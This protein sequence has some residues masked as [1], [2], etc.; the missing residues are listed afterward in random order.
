MDRIL[1]FPRLSFAISLLCSLCVSATLSTSAY[2]QADCARF[3]AVTGWTATF[4]LTGQ[5]EGADPTGF[6]TTVQRSANGSLQFGPLDGSCTA[7]ATADPSVIVN[8]NDRQVITS[9]DGSITVVQTVTASGAVP[10]PR[11]QPATLSIDAVA[12][13]YNLHTNVRPLVDA[14]IVT[15]GDTTQTLAFWVPC[16]GGNL[17]DFDVP[18]RNVPLPAS[19]TVL[20]GEA[21]YTAPADC[22]GDFVIPIQWSV[23]WTIQ[24]TGTAPPPPPP[25][26]AET[27]DDSCKVAG[28]AISV[29]NQSLG[30][31][32]DIVGTPFRLH[33]QSDRVPGRAGLAWD[34]SVQALGGWTLDVHHAYDPATNTLHLGDGTKR[35][36]DALGTVSQVGGEYIIAAEDGDELYAFDGAGKHLRI[37]DA[38][39]GA[40]RYSFAYDGE[41][42][43]TT[44][45]DGD[46]DVTTIERDAAGAPVAVIGP[47]GQRTALARN[48]DGYLSEITNPA[49]EVV[50][51]E[52]G[53]GGLLTAFTDPRGTPV[54]TNSTR[55]A[56]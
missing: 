1:R 22:S 32:V 17:E 38:V 14:T 48:P 23:S 49:G 39:T 26:V 51:A 6:P 3:A 45:T 56:G 43:L 40:A 35:S 11:S 20:S 34:A 2:A 18:V 19:G 28:S 8:V 52:Y 44:V 37:L 50:R 4:T 15:D 29:E 46:G 36:S 5:A 55:P 13:I 30:E 42:R 24:P 53:G 7:Q 9:A 16:V 33:Y 41:G 31:A 12:G 47:F 54:A 25:P 21:E 27:V 10:G